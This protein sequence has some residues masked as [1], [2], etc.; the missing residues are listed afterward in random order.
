MSDKGGRLYVKRITKTNLPEKQGGFFMEKLNPNSEEASRNFCQQPSK[1]Y[2]LLLEKAGSDPRVAAGLQALED[3]A[4]HGGW[5]PTLDARD[6]RE[7]AK[8]I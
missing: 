2:L 4:N 3:L 7:V 6:A 5:K 8:E 1:R